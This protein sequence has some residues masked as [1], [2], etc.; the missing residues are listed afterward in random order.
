MA[1]RTF[2]YQ[3]PPSPV[4]LVATEFSMLSR[5]RPWMIEFFH[6]RDLSRLRKISFLPNDRMTKLAILANDFSLSAHVISFMTAK[7]T[8]K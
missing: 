1:G 8:R 2:R 7:A 5:Q 4:A 3:T 6:R